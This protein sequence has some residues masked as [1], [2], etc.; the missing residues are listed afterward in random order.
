M[1]THE[2]GHV[3]LQHQVQFVGDAA[4]LDISRRRTLELEADRFALDRLDEAGYNTAAALTALDRAYRLSPD[5]E[6]SQDYP[7]LQERIKHLSGRVLSTLNYSRGI[8]DRREFQRC[9]RSLP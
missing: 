5:F 1:L 2:A 6:A 8:E 9:R 7:T 4:Q 3:M